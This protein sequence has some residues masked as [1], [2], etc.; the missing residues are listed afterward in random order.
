MNHKNK[1]FRFKLKIGVIFDF[2][3]KQLKMFLSKQFHFLILGLEIIKRKK[4]ISQRNY[5]LFPQV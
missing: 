3:K 1:G 5:Y 2:Q 4:F